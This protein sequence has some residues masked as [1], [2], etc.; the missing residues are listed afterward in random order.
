MARIERRLVMT[1]HDAAGVSRVVSDQVVTGLP[2]PAM[3]GSEVAQLWGSDRP[4]RYP[5]NGVMP[6]YSAFFA[7]L[8]GARLVELSLAPRSVRYDAFSNDDP[9]SSSAPLAT[10]RPGM[11]RTA[12]TDLIIVMEGRVDCELDGER[13]TLNQGDVLVQNG[14]IHAWFNPYDEPCRFL[15]VLV[16]AENSLCD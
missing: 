3:P 1:G 16:G 15:A 9:E 6:A 13:V 14:T 10:D 5:D 12:T 11:H 8:H 4:L 7:P 2:G